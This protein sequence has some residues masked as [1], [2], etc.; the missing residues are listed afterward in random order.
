[1]YFEQLQEE[2]ITVIFGN[3]LTL[4]CFRVR[5]NDAEYSEKEFEPEISKE[6]IIKLQKYEMY[7]KFLNDGVSSTPFSSAIA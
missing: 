1:M 6:D 2:V 3:V 5:V 7:L 4:T